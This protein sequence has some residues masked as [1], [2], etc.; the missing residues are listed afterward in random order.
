MSIQ[1]TPQRTPGLLTRSD[2][3]ARTGAPNRVAWVALL[4]SFGCFLPQRAS[5]ATTTNASTSATSTNT[6]AVVLGQYTIPD[7]FLRRTAWTFVAPV[8][9]K[10]TG[11]MY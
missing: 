3:R 1:S 4:L 6:P 8:D 5:P 7:T 9:W 11:G 10:K 2:R